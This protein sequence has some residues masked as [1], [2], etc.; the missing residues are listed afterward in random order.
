[1][2]YQFT[3]SPDFPPERISGWFI[4]NTW[5]QRTMNEAIHLELYDG[6]DPQRAAI[7]DDKVDLIYANP[8]DA[9]MLVREKGFVA[10]A[11]QRQHS[12]EAIIATAADSALNRIEDMQAGTRIATT[13]DPDVNMLGMIMIEPAN[14]N[15]ANT[16]TTRVEN[17]VLVAKS[18]ISGNSD[19]G[20]FF[21]EAFDE[22]SALTRSRLK[23]LVRSQIFDIHHVL[24]LGP[25]L[26]ARRAEFESTL[27]GMADDVKGRGVLDAL[28][29]K[30]WDA[31]RDEDVEFM[32][33]LMETLQPD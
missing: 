31:M 19:I 13:G 21:A 33:D 26:Q 7:R 6:F 12:D 28:G 16:S 30:A 23:V 32:I 25:R 27:L 4:F 8:Y 2:S 29:L 20:F 5:L 24:L 22:L 3:V 10:V 15:A 11:K 17:Y 9:S 18:V 1:M 14:L